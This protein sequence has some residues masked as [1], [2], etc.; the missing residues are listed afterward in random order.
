MINDACAHAMPRLNSSLAPR[1]LQPLLL[2]EISS[3]DLQDLPFFKKGG[4]NLT[5][6]RGILF[7]VVIPHHLLEFDDFALGYSFHFF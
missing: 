3:R 6:P 2:I 1:V 5:F 7:T 4:I